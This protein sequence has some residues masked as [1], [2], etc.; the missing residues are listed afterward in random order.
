MFI[1]L[2]DKDR[3]EVAILKVS[4]GKGQRDT[5]ISWKLINVKTLQLTHSETLNIERMLKPRSINTNKYRK[6][7]EAQVYY[8]K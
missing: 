7:N 5:M 3:E 2:K 6:N 8:Y 1:N 4:F